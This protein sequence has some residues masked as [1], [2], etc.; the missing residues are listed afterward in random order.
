MS[1]ER[2]AGA[3]LIFVTGNGQAFNTRD[4]TVYF[5]LTAEK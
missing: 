3:A 1:T 5:K 4:L 2:S